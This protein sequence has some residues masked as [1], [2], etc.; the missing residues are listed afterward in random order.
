VQQGN[1]SAFLARAG[2]RGQSAWVIGEVT[3]GRGIEV[4]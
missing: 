1:L 4:K 2:E 3:R